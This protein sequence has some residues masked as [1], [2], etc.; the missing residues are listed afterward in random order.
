MG[1]VHVV[2]VCGEATSYPLFFFFF[3]FFDATKSPAAA[4][5]IVVLENS[6]RGGHSTEVRD[7]ARMPPEGYEVIFARRGGVPAVVFLA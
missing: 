5:C 3:F 6:L 2:K 4:A 1:P 7:T